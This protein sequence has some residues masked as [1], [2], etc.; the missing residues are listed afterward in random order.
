M[1]KK[2][3]PNQV[4]VT[5]IAEEYFYFCLAAAKIIA[6]ISSHVSWDLV[7]LQNYPQPIDYGRHK[8]NMMQST[9]TKR[10]GEWII[11]TYWES[12]MED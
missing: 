8:K 2:L 6:K 10:N 4:S 3:F 12:S 11:N 7:H 9:A 5:Q 1:P